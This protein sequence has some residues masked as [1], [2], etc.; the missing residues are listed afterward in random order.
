MK[1]AKSIGPLLVSSLPQRDYSLVR[2]FC[3]CELCDTGVAEIPDV[4][5]KRS[6]FCGEWCKILVAGF[7]KMLVMGFAEVEQCVFVGYLRI[8]AM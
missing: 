7:W 5:R 8:L 1:I 3:V 6:E 4:A 2:T